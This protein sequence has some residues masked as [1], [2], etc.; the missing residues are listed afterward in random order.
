[1]SYTV[2][3]GDNSLDVSLSELQSGDLVLATDQRFYPVSSFRELRPCF[4]QSPPPSTSDMLRDLGV[5]LLVILIIC[6]LGAVTVALMAPRRSDE[7][8]TKKDRKYIR[9]RDG[10]T[11]F[12]CF[13]YAP[14]GHVDHRVSRANGGSNDYDNLTWACASCNLSKGPMNDTEFLALFQ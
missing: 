5:T 4:P 10:E 7:P 3:R 11:C 6:L 2:L 13:S 14:Y 8:L 9:Q 12:Y 1:M